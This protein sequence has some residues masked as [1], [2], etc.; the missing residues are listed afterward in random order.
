M[1]QVL[2]GLQTLFIL[3]L[4]FGSYYMW[5]NSVEEAGFYTRVFAWSLFGVGLFGCI[6]WTIFGLWQKMDTGGGIPQQCTECG[7]KL[8]TLVRMPKNRR[9]MLWG[10]VT[11][12]GCGM[13]YDKR[14]KKLG[15]VTPEA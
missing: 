4:G 2:Q 5:R 12:P 3:C 10:G 9:E 6:I 14:G 13:Q 1:R 8:P 7:K 15:K 11:C